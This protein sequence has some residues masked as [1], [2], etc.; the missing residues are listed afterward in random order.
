MMSCF[1]F[2][3]QYL[4]S[5]VQCPISAGRYSLFSDIFPKH[6][7]G[8]KTGHCCLALSC[9]IQSSN[10]L[11]QSQTTQKLNNSYYKLN[12]TFNSCIIKLY[13]TI[14]NI[15]NHTLILHTNT[16]QLQH[17]IKTD[18]Q[19]MAYPCPDMTSLIF[20]Q[21]ISIKAGVSCSSVVS[22]EPALLLDM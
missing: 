5:A 2:L 18:L 15:Y 7:L 4:H 13:T 21:N 16:S 6:R 9:S 8:E 20:S 19:Y 17:Y 1:P 22:A 14:H 12:I 10:S 3:H 11:T